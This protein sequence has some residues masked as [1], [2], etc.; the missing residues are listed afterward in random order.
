MYS[1]NITFMVSLLNFCY[2]C[3]PVSMSGGWGM[4]AGQ[5]GSVRPRL[6][7]VGPSD[8]GFTTSYS[9]W[10]CT[11]PNRLDAHSLEVLLD[12][13]L[14]LK[15]LVAAWARRAFAQLHVVHQLCSFLAR[16]LCSLSC[17]YLLNGL[18]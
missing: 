8:L 4:D 13:R 3:C 10:G 18:L 5:Q 9:G 14:Q 1:L 2:C 16:K 12:S 7:V 6:C 15:E 11:A 17:G